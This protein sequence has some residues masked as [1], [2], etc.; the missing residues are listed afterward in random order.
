MYR[1]IDL[2]IYLINKVVSAKL[3]P[4][5]YRILTKRYG[6]N[7]QKLLDRNSK[8]LYIFIEQASL[9]QNIILLLISVE[10]FLRNLASKLG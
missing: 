6:R 7:Y 4:N 10:E 3:F 8:C 9:Y 2:K 5:P 1:S